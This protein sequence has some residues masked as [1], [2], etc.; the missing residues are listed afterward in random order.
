[1]I[2]NS[3]LYGV[4]LDSISGRI[5]KQLYQSADICINGFEKTDFNDNTFDLAVGNVPF[6]GYSLNEKKYNKYHFHIH[7]HFF[8]KALDKV[9]PNGIVAFVTSKGTLDKKNPAV[10]KYLAERAELVGAVRLPNNAFKANAGTEVTTD[11]IFLQKRENSVELTP[12]TTPEWVNLGINKDGFAVN[13]YFAENPDMVLGQIVQG[14]KLYG[15]GSDDTT[16][17][18]FENSD[19]KSLLNKAVSNIHFDISNIKATPHIS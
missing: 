18:P 10:R 15:H 9:K 1:M 14:N 8:A 11:I 3:S 13:Q 19:L 16:C 12:E 5:A 17:I 4:E 6:G 7:D 2:Q